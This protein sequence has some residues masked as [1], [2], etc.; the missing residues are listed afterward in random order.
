MRATPLLLL[1]LAGCPDDGDKN[2]PTLWLAPKGSET[3]LRLV[4][5]EPDPY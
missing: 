1:A 3:Q 4:D 2:P 5:K